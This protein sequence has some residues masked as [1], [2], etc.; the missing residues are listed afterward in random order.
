MTIGTAYW[1]KVFAETPGMDDLHMNRTLTV[2]KDATSLR[3]KAKD[4]GTQKLGISDQL[5]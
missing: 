5:C 4:Y 2:I 1:D 3:Y